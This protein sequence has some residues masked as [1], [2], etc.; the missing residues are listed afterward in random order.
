MDQLPSDVQYITN[1]TEQ[2]FSYME[3][4]SRNNLS[5]LSASGDDP[6][7][8]CHSQWKDGVDEPLKDEKIHIDSEGKKLLLELLTR[9]KFI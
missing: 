4:G 3:D 8:I 5:L 6:E 2:S 7:C 9:S 1:D